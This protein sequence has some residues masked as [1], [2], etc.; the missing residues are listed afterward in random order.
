MANSNTDTDL[1]GV[2]RSVF[3]D[4]LLAHL[5]AEK[6]YEALMVANAMA[7]AGR[8]AELGP[9]ETPSAAF[10]A[11]L[12]GYLAQQGTAEELMGKLIKSLRSNA[13]GPHLT[14]RAE[15]HRI[16]LEEAERRVKIS[17]PRYLT[18]VPG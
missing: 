9:L 12:G 6:K 3:R 14:D 11:A 18:K 10:E 5:P 7:I 16:L 15:L 17:N 8:E 4:E 2:A 13:G 1:L